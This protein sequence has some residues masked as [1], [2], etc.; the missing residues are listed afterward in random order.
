MAE[1]PSLRRVVLC[2]FLGTTCAATDLLR[3]CDIY[4][5]AGTPCVAAHSVTRAL[6]AGYRGPLYQL[7]RSDGVVRPIGP[8]VL[9]YAD[10]TAQDAFCGGDSCVVQTIYDQS[11]MHNDLTPSPASPAHYGKPGTPPRWEPGTPVDAMR[12]PILLNGTKVYGLRFE[13]GDGYRIDKTKGIA[14]GN[15]Q[16][17]M[18][19]VTSGK[20]FNDLCCFDY[21]NAETD[22]SDD[23]DGT[24]EAIYFGNA[25]W[26]NNTGV[27]AGPWVAADLEN[28]M[29]YGQN[30]SALTNKPL[31]HD[32]V[33][34]LLK[35]R[36]TTMVLRGGNAAAGRLQT[37][38]DGPRPPPAQHG[39][40]PGE[41][42]SP[43]R[44]QGA[45]I[46]GIGGDNARGAIGVFYEGCMTQGLS[47]DAADDLVQD[48]IVAARYSA[49]GM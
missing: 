20:V 5:A 35:G 40:K 30:V 44:K 17:S 27:G 2:W 21:G 18:Y 19:M 32:F 1:W 16:E 7:K 14:T 23:G 39:V 37:M 31:T 4:S 15:E 25:H 12:H 13:Q 43:M 46:L 11:P 45:I 22:N 33:T 29:Y 26:Q 8:T 38:F 3:P 9:G 41:G 48:N 47:T 24:M 6:Y 49:S 28:G 34:A 36:S 10:A 42:Y